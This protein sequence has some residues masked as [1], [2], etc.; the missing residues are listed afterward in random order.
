[1]AQ[2]GVDKINKLG[3][4]ALMLAANHGHAHCVEA[5]LKV[6]QSELTTRQLRPI[7]TLHSRLKLTLR[8][9]TMRVRL[10]WT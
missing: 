5:L 6:D 7:R 10:L 4:T 3:D 8:R 2:I 1:M 9:L